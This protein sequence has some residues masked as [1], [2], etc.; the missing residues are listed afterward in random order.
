MYTSN[1]NIWKPAIPNLKKKPINNKNQLN[2]EYTHVGIGISG[3][4]TNL[5]FGGKKK[6]IG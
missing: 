3:N 1:F 6:W 5:V 2:P 4:Y